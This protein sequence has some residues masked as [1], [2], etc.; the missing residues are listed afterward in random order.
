MKVEMR[1]T[2]DGK[3]YGF[4]SDVRFTP[5]ASPAMK[6]SEVENLAKMLCDAVSGFVADAYWK[7]KE[8]SPEA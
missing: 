6:S 1:I 2:I 8:L 4:E 7:D 5:V 3:G